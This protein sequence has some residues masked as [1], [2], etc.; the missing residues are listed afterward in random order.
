M[1]ITGTLGE[2]ITQ[3]RIENRMS[4]KDLADFLYV[5]Q[6]TVSRWER[7]VR[8]PDDDLIIKMARRFG[9]DPEVLLHSAPEMPIVILVDDE[10]LSL[11]VNV[12]LMQENAPGCK[13]YGFPDGRST[14]DFAARKRID[15]AFLD[16]DLFRESGLDLAEKLSG[17]CPDINIIFLTGHPEFMKQAFSLHVSGYVLKPM[18]PEDFLHEMNH[19]RFPVAGLH[20]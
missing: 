9:A 11:E 4:Q 19:L 5:N 15:V 10:P 8:F 12:P 1:A 20:S 3:L 17:I 6:A 2:R 14:L 16:I 13:V 18:S 7:G